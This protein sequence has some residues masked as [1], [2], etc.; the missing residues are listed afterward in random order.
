[1]VTSTSDPIACDTNEIP[2]KIELHR[3]ICIFKSML[4]MFFIPSSISIPCGEWATFYLGYY[5]S[6]VILFY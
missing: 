3:S 5:C 6:F 2:L 4:N 1:M